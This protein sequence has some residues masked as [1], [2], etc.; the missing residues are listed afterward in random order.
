MF[1]YLFLFWVLVFILKKLGPGQTPYFTWAESNANG[2]TLCSPWF[3][4][5]SIR[6]GSCEVRRL[7]GDLRPWQT[8]THCCGHIVADTNIS[9]FAHAH[10]CCG[11]KFCVGDKKKFSDF[12]QKHFVPATNVCQFAQPKKN[13]EQQCVLVCAAWRL[14]IHF[15]SR[16]FARLR[17]M[18]NN[19]SATMCPRLPGPL[20][21]LNDGNGTK[22]NATKQKTQWAER[23][24]FF[25]VLCKTTTWN[26]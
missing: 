20:V 13:H 15:V 23:W 24:L 26:D 5:I 8:R 7:T 6:F 22:Q 19:V 3:S 18:S 21:G 16:A 12:E 14:S 1:A 25:A 9:P 11:H 4:R 10:I 17:N 2:K